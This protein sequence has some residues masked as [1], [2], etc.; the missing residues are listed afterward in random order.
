MSEA[1]AEERYR[2]ILDYWFGETT[3]RP[4][5]LDAFKA[6]SKLWFW[7][8]PE[9]DE[10]IRKRF[11]AEV[12]RAE[13]GELD[14]WKSVPAGRLALVVLLDQFPRNLYR[15]T[16]RAFATDAAAIK[17]VEE[18]I[19]LGMDKKFTITERYGFYMPFMHIE[20]KK[21]QARCCDLFAKLRE[22]A[23]ETIKAEIDLAHKYAVRH[24][25]IVDRF[26]RFPHRNKC[27]GRTSTP[28]EEAFLKEPNSSF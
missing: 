3:K 12:E 18:G 22:E 27:L 11:G 13:K 20:D 4:D 17:L 7:K 14:S 10:T 25:E 5:D 21:A 15:D 26:G 1:A 2:A 8:N 9:T 6:L 16:A 28:E 19:E 24:R 23:P